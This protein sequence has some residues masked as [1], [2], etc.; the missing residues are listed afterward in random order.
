MSPGVTEAKT[1]LNAPGHGN[2]GCDPSDTV[3]ASQTWALQKSSLG[4]VRGQS[5]LKQVLP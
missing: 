1:P 3:A 4:A 5:P 2:T